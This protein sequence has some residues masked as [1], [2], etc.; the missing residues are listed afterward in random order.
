MPEGIDLDNLGELV[1]EVF[2]GL[3]PL[4][5]FKGKFVKVKGELKSRGGDRSTEQ[6]VQMGL[7][8]TDIEVIKSRNDIPF[9]WPVTEINF[10][11]SQAAGSAYGI[12]STSA[13]KIMKRPVKFAELY[14]K[15]HELKFTKGHA[16]Q[17][18]DKDGNWQD[19]ELTAWEVKSIEG[20]VSEGSTDNT[21]AV[22]T[23]DETVVVELADGKTMSQIS[24]A[25]LAA[26]MS[27]TIK[28]IAIED[29]EEVYLANLVT[30]G[31]LTKDDDG[32]FHTA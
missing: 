28:A 2:E 23:N 10:A 19:V 32:T 9:P 16:V 27:D 29:K 8:F 20:V 5:H 7:E 6:Y 17:R 15:M 25:M 22:T 14:G 1:L 31:K 18:P 30:L 24:K 3:H 12:Y 21:P 4:I 13:A 11:Q 26:D